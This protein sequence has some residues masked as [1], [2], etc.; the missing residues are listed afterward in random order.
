MPFSV[1][2]PVDNPPCN[3][4]L[5]LPAIECFWQGAPDLVLARQSLIL[6]CSVSFVLVMAL[7]AA[8]EVVELFFEPLN[9]VFSMS[10]NDDGTG[11]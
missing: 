1:F 11:P 7:A 2:G 6:F 10:G 9:A 8:T 3:R 4:H 5:V